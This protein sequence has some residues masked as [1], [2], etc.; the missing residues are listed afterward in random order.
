M[1]EVETLL[2]I[3]PK[4]ISF[5]NKI[6]QQQ[7]PFSLKASVEVEFHTIQNFLNENNGYVQ[8]LKGSLIGLNQIEAE[9]IL[10]NNKKISDANVDI[11]PFFVKKVSN[12]PENIILKV[13][14]PF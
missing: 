5:V 9:K 3:N 7:S 12:I 4:K 2:Y 10:L 6:Y 13:D 1:E 8:K 14:T 11:R